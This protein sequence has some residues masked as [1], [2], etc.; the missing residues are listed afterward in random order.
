MDSHSHF[1]SNP[2]LTAHVPSRL[3]PFHLTLNQD[4]L[5]GASPHYPPAQAKADLSPRSPPH[6]QSISWPLPSLSGPAQNPRAD[7]SRPWAKPTPEV[8]LPVSGVDSQSY[9]S[10]LLMEPMETSANFSSDTEPFGP[11]A[12]PTLANSM[13]AVDT[14]TDHPREPVAYFS[15]SES[16]SGHE[17][18]D[19]YNATRDAASKDQQTSIPA[20]SPQ[21]QE[22]S[23]DV[24]LSRRS[25][26][27]M[28]I[29]V[30]TP[31]SAYNSSQT[32][33]TSFGS[34]VG[35]G[36]FFERFRMPLQNSPSH[37]VVV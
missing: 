7:I 22:K 23:L 35:P 5:S 29:E 17:L 34:K 37:P 24:V 2:D 18:D 10:F 8:F 13:L 3:H 19:E 12:L 30:P 31:S 20:A 6:H 26:S 33:R 27:F 15:G 16:D 21:P 28:A 4:L 1:H 32:H 25:A 14:R 11:S 9:H 36:F